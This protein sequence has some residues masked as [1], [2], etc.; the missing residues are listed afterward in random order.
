MMTITGRLVHFE[1][2]LTSGFSAETAHR[3]HPA[4]P[5]RHIHQPPIAKPDAKKRSLQSDQ[6][7]KTPNKLQ[8]DGPDS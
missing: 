2:S 5:Q 6:C 4:S 7:V 8:I 3:I 1:K